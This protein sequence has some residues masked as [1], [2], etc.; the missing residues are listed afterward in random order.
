M[1]VHFTPDVK[2]KLDQLV[3]DSGRNTDEVLEEAILGLYDELA[4]VRATHDRRYDDL[5]SDRVKP[6]DGKAV[7]ARLRARG[8]LRR[9]Q[10]G[11]IAR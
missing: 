10:C 9:T 11:L 5:E 1:E 2:A 4:D 6:L 7:L 3:R 8:A